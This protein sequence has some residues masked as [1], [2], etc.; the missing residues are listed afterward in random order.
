MSLC[1]NLKLTEE[2]WFVQGD[3]IGSEDILKYIFGQKCLPDKANPLQAEIVDSLCNE[4]I[5]DKKIRLNGKS[6]N[7]KFQWTLPKYFIQTN[8]KSLD[9]YILLM[10][11]YGPRNH[12]ISDPPHFNVSNEN[13][14]IEAPALMTQHKFSIRSFWISASS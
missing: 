1:E 10:V 8:F 2:D 3:I 11:F 9:C 7:W 6:G 14:D 13:T 5:M 4:T 12:E